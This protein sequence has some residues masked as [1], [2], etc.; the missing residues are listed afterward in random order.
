[1]QTPAAI[2]KS[3]T[4]ALDH[5]HVCPFCQEFSPAR[6]IAEN[7]G[8]CL[9]CGFIQAHPTRPGPPS[10]RIRVAGPVRP[11]QVL[12]ERYRLVS[13]LG[14]GA[15]GITY[16]AEHLL[17]N[18]ACVV[19]V[20]PYRVH[21][22]SDRSVARLRS[23]ARAGFR[24][25]NP[26]VVRIQDC[27]VFEDVWYLVMEHVEGVDLDDVARCGVA[28]DWRQCHR[29]ALQAAQG[30]AAIHDQDL[31]HRDIKPGNLLLGV[32]GR[33]R[34]ADLGVASLQRDPDEA[35]FRIDVETGGTLAYAA[36]ELFE[37]RTRVDTRADLYS[38][39][40]TLYRLINGR[41]PHDSRSVFRIVLDAHNRDAQW[42]SDAP[43]DTPAWFIEAIL[44]LLASDPA[45]RFA[46][47]HELIDFLEFPTAQRARSPKPTETLKPRGVAVLPFEND[48]AGREHDWLGQAIAD[49]LAQSL[50]QEARIYVADR[51]EFAR[52]LERRGGADSVAD[53][54]EAG[55]LLG[56]ASIIRGR[57][58]VFEGVMHVSVE[59]FV[60]GA[61][62]LTPIVSLRGA[63]S[64]LAALESRLLGA[65]QVALGLEA[66]PAQPGAG[67]SFHAAL[68]AQERFFSAKRAYLRGDYEAAIELALGALSL[69]DQ[70]TDAIALAGACSARVGRYDVASEFHRRLDEIASAR[71]DQRLRAE[72]A[73][74]MGA[75][76]YFRGE[77]EAAHA[78]LIRA[79]EA[80][81]RQGLATESALICNNL[82]FTLLRLGRPQ[83]AE[84]AFKR[85]IETH[86]AHGAL[87]CLIA[88]YN[89]MGN[90]L[91]EQQRYAEAR[92]F[93]HRALRLAEE[94]DDRV[95]IGVAYM[96]LGQ[97]AFSMGH[98][99]QA[100]RELVMALTILEDT[101]FWNGLARVYECLAQLNASSGAF[102]EALRC[103][104][105]RIE[106]ARLNSNRRME[107]AA[108]RQKADVLRDMGAAEQAE[109]CLE[110][111]AE[112]ETESAAEAPASA[113][114]AGG[115][116]I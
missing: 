13:V 62:E 32:D 98:L 89:G 84:A 4:R 116:T 24:V 36:P 33:L 30:L 57:F 39:G 108:W 16:L 46:T 37:P 109:A 27:D 42:P 92:E 97:C 53:C 10:D 59:A 111:A 90:V 35:R 60:N 43:P 94:G 5:E 22:S 110:R 67:R 104:N 28:V 26:H 31:L 55:R 102:E 19:K 105:K 68:E 8:A 51:E 86:R 23:E 72:A 100:K 63:L 65:A 17:V 75:M 73:A 76:R 50:A 47:A 103:V 101:R 7:L 77:Y 80:S 71:G 99:A 112:T 12:R 3:Q 1:M 106:L 40:A 113:S 25:N 81:D 66:A 52:V 114:R 38:L 45:R 44:R 88:P 74:N 34:I 6:K 107:A 69:D 95:N 18:C 41:T 87:V 85:A 49:H 115:G 93:Y 82:G 14:A 29:F 21:E 11:G 79:I 58:Q 20:I 15:H 48:S 56:A 83:E 2:Q 61:A 78:D 9:A 70:Y 54:L 91:R 64:D 96:N